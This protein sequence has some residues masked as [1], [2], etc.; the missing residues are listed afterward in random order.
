MSHNI[1]A[2]RFRPESKLMPLAALPPVREAPVRLWRPAGFCGGRPC[3]RIMHRSGPSGQGM[4]GR[5]KPCTECASA[6]LAPL[7][8]V[9]SVFRSAGCV[10][11]A[12]RNALRAPGAPP[13][14]AWFC[15]P[16]RVSR[17]RAHGQTAPAS[18]PHLGL[19]SSASYPAEVSGPRC[20]RF[21]GKIRRTVARLRSPCSQSTGGGV[22]AES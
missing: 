4:Q 19:G 21:R 15:R 6:P 7:R 3:A 14:A 13:F 20:L 9:G 10:R 5:P 11:H 1:P 17:P 16:L 18:S 8:M 2:I 12:R 22:R